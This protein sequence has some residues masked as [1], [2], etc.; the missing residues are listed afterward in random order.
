MEGGRAR[1]VDSGGTGREGRTSRHNS[2][3]EGMSPWARVKLSYPGYN[4]NM[5]QMVFVSFLK[6][7][8]LIITQ[9]VQGILEQHDIF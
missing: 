7:F 2:T 5:C 8:Y 3:D 4:T 6:C 9:I 1:A